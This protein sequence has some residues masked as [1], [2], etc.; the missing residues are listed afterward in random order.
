M[1]E[2]VIQQL[3]EGVK[4]ISKTLHEANQFNRD[5]ENSFKKSKLWIEPFKCNHCMLKFMVLGNNLSRSKCN[6]TPNTDPQLNI[7]MGH[8]YLEGFYA[9]R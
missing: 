6:F 4:T 2:R 8:N 7:H 3:K 1:L 5:P 9:K